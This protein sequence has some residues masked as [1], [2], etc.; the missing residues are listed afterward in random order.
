MK[1]RK[2]LLIIELEVGEHSDIALGD[3]LLTS[4]FNLRELDFIGN[5]TQEIRKKVEN[6]VIELNKKGS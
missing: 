4:R 3:F 1:G 6:A 5:I 2:Y